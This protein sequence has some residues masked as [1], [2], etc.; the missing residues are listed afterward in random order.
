M[1][2]EELYEVGR[3]ALKQGEKSGAGE[4]EVFCISGRSTN[5]EITKDEVSLARESFERGVGVRVLTDGTIGFSSTSDF[6]KIN[7][8]V[9]EAIKCA[10]ASD[11]EG[12]WK[13][14][15][16]GGEYPIVKGAFHKKV[17]EV[18]IEDCLNYASDMIEGAKQPR[19]RPTSGSL[20]CL[21]YDFLILNSN[22]V[23]VGKKETFVQAFIESMAE[24]GS[25]LSTAYDFEVSRNLNID[26]FELGKSSSMLAENSLHGVKIS[27]E[28]TT[29]LF[30]PYAFSDILENAFIPSLNAENVQKNRSSLAGK[31]GEVIA[32]DELSI[33]DDGLADSGIG[34]SPSDDE[35]VP[36]QKTDIILKGELKS[37]LYDHHTASKEERSS[38]GNAT[39]T[40]YSKLPHIGIRNLTF[41]HPT[42]DL[43]AETDNGVLITS[44]IGGHTANPVSGD[45]SLDGRNAYLV[46]DGSIEEPI[47]QVMIS[48]NVFDLLKNI[49]GLDTDVRMVGNVIV[50]TVRVRDMR[51][52]G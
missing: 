12:D 24:E 45:F 34:T 25:D 37:F 11:V 13:S 41:K 52:L 21:S 48:G 38:T 29:L 42:S 4:L 22:G 35:G 14:L 8:A 2:Q 7:E 5:I 49:N 28:T 33:A 30:R 27:P 40:T 6:D 23:D 3:N 26:F 44:V 51:V 19:S 15:P 50:P 17:D 18:T 20:R 47:K 9:I 43:I 39:R 1:T 16:P 36:S 32:S 46:K 10:G 31:I